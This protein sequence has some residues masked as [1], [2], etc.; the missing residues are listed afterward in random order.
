MNND[1][2]KAIRSIITRLQVAVSAI[3]DISSEMED[4]KSEEQDYIDNLPDNLKDSERANIADA[5]VSAMDEA[6]TMLDDFAQNIVGHLESAC[7]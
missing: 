5:A 2:R 7:D 4:L 1:R 3:E 6:I